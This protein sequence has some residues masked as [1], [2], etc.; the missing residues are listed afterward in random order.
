[1][2]R[3]EI[4]AS[5]NQRAT[6]RIGDRRPIATGS[7]TAG[8][9]G[10]VSPLVQT[11]FQYIDIG[12]NLD[13]TPKMH[14]NDEI[15]LA[16][17]VEVS[18]VTNEVDIGGIRQ[19]LIGQRI[20][21][22]NIRL[23]EG[24]INVLGGLFQ[25]QAAESVAGI[26]GLSQIPLLRY[27]F[28]NVS[29]TIAEDE[30]L[31]VLRPRAVRRPDISALNLKALDI[32]TEGDVRLR[33]PRTLP[34]ATPPEPAPGETAPAPETGPGASL[35]FPAEPPAARRGETFEVPVLVENAKDA[36]AVSLQLAYDPRAV[37][38]LRIVKGNFF[39]GS[40]A[41]PVAIVERT[42]HEAGTAAVTLSRPPGSGSISGRGELAILTFQALQPGPTALGI[43]PAEIISPASQ[44]VTV[45]GAQ[46][47]LT[48][49]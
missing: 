16:V 6:L 2:Q 15:T 21:E 31:I 40:D 5:D 37:R 3:P 18:N 44:A 17:R 28:S 22:H 23:R 11:Q 4:R 49:Q 19:P 13:I 48:I 29:T 7:F 24:E 30:V 43:A 9:G 27:I 33:S 1:L 41:P 34:D 39:G 32:G 46:A 14:A 26:P 47:V 36:V 25:R 12:V 20:I 35:R 45:Q 10:T 8:V 38:L 42:E